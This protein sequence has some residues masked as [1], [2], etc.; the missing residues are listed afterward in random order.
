MWFN[1]ATFLV[2]FAVFISVWP[3]MK[4]R[5][6]PRWAYLV[7][8]S[9]VFYGWWDWRFLFLLLGVGLNDFFAGL[10][11]A[12]FPGRRR[13][14][15]TVSLL[16]DVGCLAAFKYLDF[17]LA[18]A[19]GLFSLIGLPLRM[20][21]PGLI[22][23]V[24]ISF[25][26]FQSM[27][28]T[29]DVY[30]G[31]LKPTHNVLHYFAFL[32]MFPQ[33]VAGPI[34]RASHL[35]PQLE[36]TPRTTEEG[37]WEGLR[38]IVFGYFKK[39]VVADNIA[40][41]VNSAFSSSVPI[42]S[43]PY[44]WAITL[45]FAF[46]IYCDFSGYSD[47]AL[48]LGRWMGFDFPVNF[49]HPY[50]ASSFRDFWTRW[51]ISLSSWFR[52]YVYVPLG[53][54]HCGRGRSHLYMWIAML[55]S[56]LWHGAQWTF[57]VWAAVHAFFVS[58]ERVTKLPAR[59]AK[60]PGG[61]HL[62]A[63]GVFVLVQISWVFFRAESLGQAAGILRIMFSFRGRWV[64]GPVDL[65]APLFLVGLLVLQHVFLHLRGERPPAGPPRF[66]R[67][68]LE[69]AMLGGLAAACVLFAGPGSSFIYFQF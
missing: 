16:G 8:A 51:H 42:E 25:F 13:L 32:A 11:M 44:W 5:R 30:H 53:G 60:L 19:N 31:R 27:S 65:A 36:T 58:M 17:L 63:L 3:L 37:R 54:N 15:L 14:F 57:V 20:P 6:T 64:R 46:Q 56:G 9:F 24:G 68:L 21:L 41:A 12:R 69:P 67:R 48:G 62:A 59:L 50:I 40:Q 23:P 39:V 61:R 26:T 22:L 35:L 66:A 47:I 4:R 34:V 10:A 55:V 18:N 45:L 2:F 43:S 38:L 49:R 33:L 52:D 7:V 1:S 28:Y 29:I